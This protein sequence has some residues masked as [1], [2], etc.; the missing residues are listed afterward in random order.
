[1]DRVNSGLSDAGDLIFNCQMGRGRTTSGMVAASLIA[2]TA[3]VDWT[4]LT[5]ATEQAF[6]ISDASEEEAFLQ[7]MLCSTML[8]VG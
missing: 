8:A 4:P 3:Q 6:L 1:V 2:T 7:G 5:T